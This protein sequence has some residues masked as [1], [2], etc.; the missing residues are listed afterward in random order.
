MTPKIFS[1]RKHSGLTRSWLDPL[2]HLGGESEND[3]VQARAREAFL[4]D[5]PFSEQ[6]K[7]EFSRLLIEKKDYL[8]GL[9]SDQ[10]K[11]ALPALATT[12]SLPIW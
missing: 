2:P 1:T 12:I 3:I 6:A 11:L 5:A 8:P 9:S 4:K 7:A 10:K